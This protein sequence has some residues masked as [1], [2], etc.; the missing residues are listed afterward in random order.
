MYGSN[1]PDTAKLSLLSGS[2]GRRVLWRQMPPIDSDQLRRQGGDADGAGFGSTR[3]PSRWALVVGDTIQVK[4]LII[5]GP[6]GQA[7]FQVSDGSTFDVYP[8]S[9]VVFRKNAP[10]WKDLLDVLVGRVK[11]HIEHLVRSQSE[12]RADADGGDFG[13]RHHVRYYGRRR[14]RNHDGGS[15]RRH[16]RSAARA[17]AARQRANR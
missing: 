10:N 5:T 4:Q 8:N 13:A 2:H 15:R 17:A 6:D 7:T 12:S 14:R 9:R 1:A 16:G 11:V 3:M